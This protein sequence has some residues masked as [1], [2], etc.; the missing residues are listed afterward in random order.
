MAGVYFAI[1]AAVVFSLGHVA[2][3][4]AV[5]TL[6]VIRGIAVMLV[7]A[8][9][10]VGLAAFTFED[11]DVLLQASQAG[12]LYFAAAGLVHYIAGWGFM[13]ASTRLVGASRMSAIT[14]ITPL[15]A[16]ILAILTL[17]EILNVFIGSGI[18]L[19]VIGTYFIARS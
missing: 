13:N 14:G 3:R 8:T 4:R 16:A 1:G 7:S 15:F 18:I 2:I 11:I 19:I 17:R 5:G 12:I 10:I 6:G 9:V